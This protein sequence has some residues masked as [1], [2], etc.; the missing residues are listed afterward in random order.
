MVVDGIA[1]DVVEGAAVV[2][3]VVVAGAIVDKMVLDEVLDG[4]EVGD[5]LPFG[6]LRISSGKKLQMTT[7]TIGQYTVI[8]DVK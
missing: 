8:L 6:R 1:N 5:E 2:V 4:P 3:V 7:T